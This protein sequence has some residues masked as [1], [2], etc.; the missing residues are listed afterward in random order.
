MY[1]QNNLIIFPENERKYIGSVYRINENRYRLSIRYKDINYYKLYSTYGEA[2]LELYSKNREN[3]LLIKNLIYDLDSY[4]VV[5]LSQEQYMKFD[6]D[7]LDTVQNYVLH[8]LKS[9]NVRGYYCE[10]SDKQL[11]HRL[12]TNCPA[13]L[14]VDHINGDS[15]DNR[16][17]NLRI[18]ESYVQQIN[19]SCR[20]I[21]KSGNVGVSYCKRD[22]S[23]IASFRYNKKTYK[24]GFS[25]R[26]YSNAKELAMEWI[27]EEKLR[28]IPPEHRVYRNL[29]TSI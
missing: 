15:L 9:K 23:W 2:L 24:K 13:E 7:D 6:K 19:I 16:K 22:E 20:K 18:V 25:T 8:A 21:N 1:G 5:Q 4:Y 28:V 27:A 11:F 3:Q 14:T 26:K 17:C 29:L 12:I 10:T